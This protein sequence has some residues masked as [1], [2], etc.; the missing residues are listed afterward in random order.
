VKSA[1]VLVIGGTGFIGSAVVQQLALTGAC[2]L[3]ATFKTGAADTLFHDLRWTSCDVMDEHS[4][5]VAT[6]GVDCVI[7]CYRDDENE[8][9]S[10][11]AISNVLNACEI[12]K[13][14]KLIYL[15]SAAIYGSASGEVDEWTPPLGPLH[16]YGRAKSNAERACRAKASPSFHAAIL[17][18]TLVYGPGG[19]EWFL[20]FVRS[21]KSGALGNLGAK[22]E[23]IANLIY[24][25]DL[26]R[27]CSR[28]ALS[29][30]PHFS[31]LIANG[32]EHV[33]FNNYFDEI[34]LALGDDCDQPA[35]PLKWLRNVF[36][37]CRRP[38][39]GLL[40]VLRLASR[41]VL[42]DHYDVLF[43]GIEQAT[44][45]RPEDNVKHGYTSRTY[46]SPA[47][48]QTVGLFAKTRIAEGVARS[49]EFW[50]L[51]Q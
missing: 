32:C 3:I 41:P 36:S 26:A 37:K 5:L 7:N 4:V 23:G 1:T 42:G 31:I 14:S 25:E 49:I 18:P 10:A 2:N 12:N 38:A 44:Q 24:V 9:K 35:A 19:E 48:G 39:R 11:R 45:Q 6:V 47:H 13:V 34:R 8:E 46:F 16:W 27:M 30:I 51:R 17:R 21:I 50:R 33:T 43:H 28:L 40:K 20:R 22:G 15:S 29:P